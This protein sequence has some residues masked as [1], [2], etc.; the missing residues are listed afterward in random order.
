M[1]LKSGKLFR[2]TVARISAQRQVDE[3]REWQDAITV[4]M[5]LYLSEGVFA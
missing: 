2:A 3:Y 4:E 1:A 5:L